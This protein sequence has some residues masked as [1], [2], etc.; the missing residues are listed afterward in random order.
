MARPLTRKAPAYTD[1]PELV[2][3]DGRTAR[4]RPPPKHADIAS[5][6][7]THREAV[8]RLLSDLRKEGLVE[9]VRGELVFR[10]IPRLREF[11]EELQAG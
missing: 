10:D 6:L 4:L 11:A 2:S 3:Q 1:Q 5:R 7:L 9:R 8:S